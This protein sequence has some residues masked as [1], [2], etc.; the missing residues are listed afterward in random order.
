MKFII[1]G[2]LLV[3]SFS[4]FAT[5]EIVSDQTCQSMGFDCFNSDA[6]LCVNHGE[7]RHP[8]K[9]SKAVKASY[10]AEIE[11]G[12]FSEVIYPILRDNFLAEYNNDPS[13]STLLKHEDILYIC[14]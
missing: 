7:L 6:N 4:S 10:I 8:E 5:D 3:G 13:I 1:L 12:E 11:S 9:L 14:N 2:L